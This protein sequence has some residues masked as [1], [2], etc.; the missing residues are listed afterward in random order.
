MTKTEIDNTGWLLDALKY[1]VLYWQKAVI[2]IEHYSYLN[3]YADTLGDREEVDDLLRL[4]QR[5]LYPR[6]Y[7]NSGLVW[8]FKELGKAILHRNGY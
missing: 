3:D 5:T 2:G 7:N 4:L 8:A 6:T 1:Q